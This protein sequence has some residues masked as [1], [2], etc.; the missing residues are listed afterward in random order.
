MSELVILKIY[1]LSNLIYNDLNLK[2]LTT[3]I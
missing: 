1:F 2:A 3:Q